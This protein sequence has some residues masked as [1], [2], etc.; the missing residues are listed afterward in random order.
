MAYVA[1][2]RA[3]N[4]ENLYI[5]CAS[6]PGSPR[7][8]VIYRLGPSSL[9]CG[10]VANEYERLQRLPPRVHYPLP[11][12]AQAAASQHDGIAI[13]FQNNCF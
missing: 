7:L 9:T 1:V 12:P 3:T 4:Y 2:S 5:V 10:S 13:F 8:R 11:P 6:E